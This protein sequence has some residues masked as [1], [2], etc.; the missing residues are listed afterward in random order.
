MIIKISDIHSGWTTKEW[1]S[2]WCCSH[3]V[4]FSLLNLTCL[5]PGILWKALMT[6]TSGYKNSQGQNILDSLAGLCW[7]SL[8]SAASYF[9]NYFSSWEIPRALNTLGFCKIAFW[10]PEWCVVYEDG[11]EYELEEVQSTARAWTA[12]EETYCRHDSASSRWTC[13]SWSFWSDILRARITSSCCVNHWLLQRDDVSSLKRWNR[14]LW[15]CN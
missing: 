2:F 14:M 10:M 13:L 1:P 15:R 3:F 4:F 9:C 12:A 7:S 5:F 6:L 11:R 8:S